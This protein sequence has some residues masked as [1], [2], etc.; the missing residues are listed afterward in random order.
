MRE[1]QVILRAVTPLIAPGRSAKVPNY[2]T[3]ALLVCRLRSTIS[4]CAV[5]RR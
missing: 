4:M 5:S 1:K 3:L 2:E